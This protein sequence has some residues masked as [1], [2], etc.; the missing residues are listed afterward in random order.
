MTNCLIIC[1]VTVTFASIHNQNMNSNS[2]TTQGYFNSNT[3]KA[4]GLAGIMV[5]F[6]AISRLL[7]QYLPN[8]SALESLALFGGAYFTLKRFAFIVPLAAYM[9]SDFVIN[10]TTARI[11]FPKHEGLVFFSN[12]ML[13]TLAGIVLVV[14]FGKFVMKNINLKTGIAGILGAT[15]LFWLVSNIGSFISNPM[16]TKDIAG[17]AMC[18][19]AAIPFLVKSLVGNFIFGGV[20]FGSYEWLRNQYP[21]LLPVKVK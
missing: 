15:F 17:L 12:Y 5:F 3:K 10:N 14:I 8:V 20:L 4:I 18:Y 16:Y 1:E 7:L 13:Y 2:N 19:T 6:G 9:I 11:Y 21:T